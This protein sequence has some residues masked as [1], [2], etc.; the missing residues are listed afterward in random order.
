[1][2]KRFTVFSLVVVAACVTLALQAQDQAKEEKFKPTCPVSGKEAVD[3]ASVDYKGGKVYFCCPGCP[4]EFKANTAKYAVKANHQLVGTKQAVEMKCPLT[5]RPLNKETAIDVQGVKVAFCCNNCK[6]KVAAAKGEE[7]LK[8]VFADK[9]FAQGF[10]V[11]KE[12]EES[13]NQ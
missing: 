11:K 4:D 13:K 8:L 5:G 10:E 2:F 6:G 9:P 3:S 1:M 7:Q 12:K